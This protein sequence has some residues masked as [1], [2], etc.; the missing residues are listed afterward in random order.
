L[1]KIAPWL[2]RSKIALVINCTRQD[3]A[4]TTRES[5]KKFRK[6]S[7]DAL[8]KYLEYSVDASDDDRKC[9]A[10]RAARGH[11]IRRLLEHSQ[12]AEIVAELHVLFETYQ[13]EITP[14]DMVE[15]MNQSKEVVCNRILTS[16]NDCIEAI[17]ILIESI[18]TPFS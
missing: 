16:G 18:Q 3:F 9:A 6:I 15:I 8:G 1:Q 14:N 12:P 2:L 7:S 17:D 4:K 13:F 11:A 5:I 10:F